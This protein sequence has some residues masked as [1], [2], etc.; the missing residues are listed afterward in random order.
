MDFFQHSSNNAV[1][2]AP[3]G[4][5][6]EECRALPITRVQFSDATPAC[7]SFWRPTPQ[8]LRLLAA[9]QPIRLCVLG[10]THPPLLVGVD[11]DGELPL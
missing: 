11:G 3:V 5:P 2:G 4:V 7:V 1:L 10:A 9:G 6:I 8:E